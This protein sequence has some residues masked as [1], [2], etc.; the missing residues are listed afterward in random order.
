MPG[1]LEQPPRVAAVLLVD[2]YG[3]C[4]PQDRHDGRE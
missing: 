4:V 1:P 3:L 2:L